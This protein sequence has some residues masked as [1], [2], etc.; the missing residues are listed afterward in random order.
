MTINYS[1]LPHHMQG[2]ARRYIEDGVPP[3]DFLELVLKNDLCGAFGR[4]DDENTRAMR[5]WAEW[6]YNI[7]GN[8]WKS[9]ENV[10]EWIEKGGI[11]GLQTD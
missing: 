6:L 2:A 3:G 7:P 4:A 11:N 8:A 1:N 5:E 9:A 10:T